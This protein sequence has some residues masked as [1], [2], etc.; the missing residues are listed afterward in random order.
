MIEASTGSED[1]RWVRAFCIDGY[2]TRTKLS[3]FQIILV[4]I[5][6]IAS[7]SR[8]DSARFRSP[9]T[10]RFCWA[11]VGFRRSLSNAHF[12]IRP[13][14]FPQGIADFPDRGIGPYAVDDVR[15]GVGF[16]DAPVAWDDRLLGSG[17]F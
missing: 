13:I 3:G 6:A 10:S 12:L 1:L 8:C 7:R 16:A 14:H 17:A 5:P 11:G 2:S 15:H 9:Q 4:R